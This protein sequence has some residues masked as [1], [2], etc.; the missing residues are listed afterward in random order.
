MG[1]GAEQFPV[2]LRHPS[3]ELVVFGLEAVGTAAILVVRTSRRDREQVIGK[4]P[5]T[6]Q[7]FTSM[8]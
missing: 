4:S 7:S 5:E 2:S 1:M 3:V 6:P 8:M